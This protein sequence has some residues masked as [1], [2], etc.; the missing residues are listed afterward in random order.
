MTD[1]PGFEI[2]AHTADLRAVL[3]APDA[4]GLAQAAVDFARA[5]L[6][7]ESRVVAVETRVIHAG[8]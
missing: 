5:V 3:S 1:R 2:L 8:G 4:A 7:G 6:V